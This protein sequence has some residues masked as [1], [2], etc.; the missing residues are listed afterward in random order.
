MRMF[1]APLNTGT[2]IVYW[3]MI[4]KM[5]VR[6]FPY[7]KLILF[8]IMQNGLYYVGGGGEGGFIKGP[9]ALSVNLYE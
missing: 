3:S 9:Q 4:L 2:A 7:L 5:K 6:A 8:C 1:G